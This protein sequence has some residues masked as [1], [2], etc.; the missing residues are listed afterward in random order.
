MPRQRKGNAL[1]GGTGAVKKGDGDT[2][3]ALCGRVIQSGVNPQGPVIY[4]ICGACKKL[5][6]HNPGSTASLR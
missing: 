4:S 1:S 2:L 3:C 6:H 5:P